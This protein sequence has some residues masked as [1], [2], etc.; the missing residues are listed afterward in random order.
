MLAPP[1]FYGLGNHTRILTERLF[2]KSVGN[3]I[4]YAGIFVPVNLLCSLGC[5]LLLNQKVR[6]RAFFRGPFF[7]PSITPTVATVILWMWLFHPHVGLINHF[8]AQV[9]IHPG[10]GWLASTKWSK[11]ALIIM[12]LWASA[13]RGTMLILLAGLQGVP[14]ERY[15][16]AEIDGANARH[17]LLRIA[18]PILSPSIFFN[19]LLE[20]S[21]PYRCSPPPTWRQPGT[22][23]L[24]AARRGRRCSTW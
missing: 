11:P 16:A 20:S 24:R 1:K 2:W 4:Y 9:G 6:G 17:R 15:E 18:L 21:A 5:A 13:G 22:M 12:G 7:L 8:L 19:L 23:C 10:P 3:T 14:S